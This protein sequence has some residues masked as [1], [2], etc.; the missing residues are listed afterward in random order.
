MSNWLLLQST[1]NCV[2]RKNQSFSSF[3]FA[4]AT[5]G[6]PTKS[7]ASLKQNLDEISCQIFEIDIE[8]QVRK[9]NSGFHDI[10]RFS[11]CTLIFPGFSG[12]VG[13][14]VTYFI[15]VLT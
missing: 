12:R 8:I 13:A 4:M 7:L 5:G 9:G 6:T 2:M 14:L 3:C 15:T 10:S 1:E 11:R